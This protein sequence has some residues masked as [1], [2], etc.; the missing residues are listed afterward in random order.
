MCPYAQRIRIPPAIP[1]GGEGIYFSF[2]GSAWE[3]MTWRLRLHYRPE[4]QI[5]TGR[6]PE[7]RKSPTLKKRCLPCRQPFKSLRKGEEGDN[8]F[9]IGFLMIVPKPRGI[10][11]SLL[12]RSHRVEPSVCQSRRLGTL[13]KPNLNTIHRAFKPRLLE[14]AEFPRDGPLPGHG[15]YQP[16]N[17]S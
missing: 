16:D 5:D 6:S 3:C 7:T 8:P 2:P 12:N 15:H 9:A 10:P 4:F 1:R 13:I 11:G 17:Q 14:T